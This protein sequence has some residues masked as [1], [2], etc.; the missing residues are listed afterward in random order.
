MKPLDV[1]PILR[2]KKNHMIS[3]KTNFIII[4]IW[5]LTDIYKT[6]ISDTGN[7]KTLRNVK[8]IGNSY[9]QVYPDTIE[10][11]REACKSR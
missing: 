2:P 10:E 3:K 5:W 7:E 8:I 1:S 4:S 11:C 6:Y 9:D